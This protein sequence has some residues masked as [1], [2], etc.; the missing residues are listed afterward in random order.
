M[1]E[2]RR[3]KTEDRRRLSASG[4][5]DGEKL[6]RTLSKQKESDDSLATI[7]RTRTSSVS[8]KVGS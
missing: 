6:W 7:H 8:V 3:R 5:N 1:T 2:N 4:G